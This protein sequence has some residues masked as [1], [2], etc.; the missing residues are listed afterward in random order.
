MRAASD[1]LDCLQGEWLGRGTLGRERS[2]GLNDVS[3]KV[4][5]WRTQDGNHL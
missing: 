4:H 5:T 1:Q 2:A 3:F